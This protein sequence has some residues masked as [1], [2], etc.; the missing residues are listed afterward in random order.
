VVLAA[1]KNN[2]W[3]LQYASEELQKDRDFVVKAAKCL[4]E[5][6]LYNIITDWIQ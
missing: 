4:S 6:S 2:W 3:A 1:I 5:E